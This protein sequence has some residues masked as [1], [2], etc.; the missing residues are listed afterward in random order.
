MVRRNEIIR[1]T[2][3]CFKCN[4]KLEVPSWKYCIGH[5]RQP[6]PKDPPPVRKYYEM[7]GM[8]QLHAIKKPVSTRS[9]KPLD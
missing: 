9:K 5:E 6:M 8:T 2:G 1:S 3:Y 7:A 4:K